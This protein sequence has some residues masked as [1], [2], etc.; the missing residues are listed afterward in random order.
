MNSLTLTSHFVMGRIFIVDTVPLIVESE[1]DQLI[2]EHCENIYEEMWR[3]SINNPMNY[4]EFDS[5]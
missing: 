3:I 1:P 2:V 4:L 5:L